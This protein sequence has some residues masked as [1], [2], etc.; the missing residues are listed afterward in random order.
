[1][2]TAKTMIRLGGCPGWSESALG[3]QPHC[4][5]CRVATNVFVQLLLQFLTYQFEF[6][7]FST[8]FKRFDLILNHQI[9]FWYFLMDGWVDWDF[10]SFSTVFQSYQVRWEGDNER[11]CAMEPR[12]RLKRFPPPAGIGPG[13]LDQQAIASP[14]ELHALWT[15]FFVWYS[16]FRAH[17]VGTYIGLRNS[18]YSL[19][20]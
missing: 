7:F 10:T 1:M 13:P 9:F 8:W 5:F 18:D 15:Q 11:L 19:N 2:R 17:T 20:Y 3:A 14:T 6:K 4:W 16:I 12:L